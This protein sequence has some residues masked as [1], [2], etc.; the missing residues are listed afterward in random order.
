MG[1]LLAAL[2]LTVASMGQAISMAVIIFAGSLEAALPRA[3]GSFVLAAGVFT[4]YVAWRSQIVPTATVIQ[5]GPAIVLVAI[6]AVVGF[7]GSASSGTD[8]F[9]LIAITTMATGAISWLLG[10]I[11]AGVLVHYLP[12]T[13]VAAFMAGTGWLL[14][15]G[16]MD[17]MVGFGIG[18]DDVG[19]LVK[20]DMAKFWVPGVLLGIAVWL[21]GRS[22]RLPN[23]AASALIVAAL[24][25]F[26]LIVVS[27]SSVSAVEAD[28]W[29]IGPFPNASGPTLVTPSELA[30]ADWGAILGVLPGM[31]SVVA[32]SV[33]VMLL[34]L[35]GLESL[36]RKG[37]DIDREIR[38]A[39]VTNLFLGPVGTS[40]GFHGLGDTVL[41][42]RLGVKRRVVPIAAGVLMVGFGILGV[43]LIG[44]VPRI[45]VGALLVAVG[46]ALLEQWF[47][48]LVRLVSRIEQLLSV[49]IVLTIGVVGILEGIGV[50]LAAACAVFVVRYSRVDPVRAAH[51]GTTLRSRVDRPQH[52]VAALRNRAD[53][54]AVFELQGY[55]FFGSLVSLRRTM[56]TA[57]G[58][59]SSPS[60][61]LDAVILDV[62][63]V[64]GIDTSSY[65]LIG[66]IART[67]GDRG[68]E[69]LISSMSDELQRSLVRAI[70][71]LDEAVSWAPSLDYAL[72]AAE[73]KQ[74][75]LLEEISVPDASAASFNGMSAELEAV[76]DDI[77]FS[78][79]S[80][81]LEQ[82][83]ESDG[84]MVVLSGELTAYHVAADGRRERLRRF[85]APTIIGEVGFLTGQARSAQIVAESD[86]TAKWL[87]VERHHSLR[88]TQ[89]DLV[90]ELYEYILLEQADRV[91]SLSRGLAA[92]SR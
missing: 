79:G 58:G 41:L 59:D 85:G 37:F 54:V 46:A 47:I 83:E 87:P 51:S 18:A 36:D 57:L 52:Q 2:V 76:F 64:T 24:G 80:I 25:G 38:L 48:G 33:I 61:R 45:V 73:D 31:A 91:V 27:V 86:G 32:V 60:E 68:T 69:L 44:Y 70:P 14:I 12:T 5:D 92:K 89:P 7:G 17:G 63:N 78:A 26:Y 50:G 53:R 88:E 72:E 75:R 30:D 67:L 65:S 1:D 84:L 77:G 62:R 8:I 16:G 23:T 11:R 20:P 56:D 74:L 28:G 19:A 13:V 22:P 90:L 3:I 10:W 49:A 82:G 71:D 43:G 81:V 21:V 34:N 35:T 40:P 42:R 55:L 29:F 4:I 15:K 39:G 9:V 66:D 6:A